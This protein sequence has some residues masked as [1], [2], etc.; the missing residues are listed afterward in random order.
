MKEYNSATDI[1]EILDDI[2]NDKTSAPSTRNVATFFAK[3]KVLPF[4]RIDA[5]RQELRGRI[6]LATKSLDT[7]KHSKNLENA[8]ICALASRDLYR[9]EWICWKGA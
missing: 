4:A 7:G 5:A 1:N 2:I 6:K 3:R 9:L 8:N